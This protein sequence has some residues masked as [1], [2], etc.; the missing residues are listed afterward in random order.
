[1]Y[2]EYNEI[3]GSSVKRQAK[4]YE[5]ERFFGH[6]GQLYFLLFLSFTGYLM[7]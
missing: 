2:M 7:Y 3:T 5:E 4:H 1:M 6:L